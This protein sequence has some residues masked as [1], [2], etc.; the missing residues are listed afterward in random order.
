M[1]YTKEQIGKQT[2]VRAEIDM[3][4]A[5]TSPELKE[6]FVQLN[7]DNVNNIILDL[8]HVKYCDSS[9][10]SAILVGHR[11]CKDTGGS[12]ILCSLKPAVQKIVTIAQLNKVLSIAENQDAAVALILGQNIHEI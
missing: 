9:G 7:R 11:L 10:L 2:I 4:D 5:S 12:L 6:I 8:N 3:L 1:A